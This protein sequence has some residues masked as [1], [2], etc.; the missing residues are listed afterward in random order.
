MIENLNEYASITELIVG[1]KE[2]LGIEKPDSEM[3]DWEIA[4]V[5]K[6]LAQGA[7]DNIWVDNKV[8]YGRLGI[9]AMLSLALYEFPDF[10]IRHGLSQVN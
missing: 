10:Y 5:M 8:V 3:A 6:L 9:S 1:A 7:P 4:N 2:M